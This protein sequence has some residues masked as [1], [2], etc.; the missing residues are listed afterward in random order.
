[1]PLA[2]IKFTKTADARLMRW[3]LYLQ[4]FE[5]DIRYI[6]GDTNVGANLLSRLV[7]GGDEQE[8]VQTPRYTCTPH[9]SNKNSQGESGSEVDEQAPSEMLSSSKQHCSP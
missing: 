4:Q 8:P 7:K 2:Q 6:K 5:F 9:E 1:M 3:A